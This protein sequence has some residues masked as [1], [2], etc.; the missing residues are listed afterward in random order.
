[1]SDLH[2]AIL[3]W[4]TLLAPGR[5]HSANAQAISSA[6][7][8]ER[9]LFADDDLRTKT[10]ALVVSMA[11]RESSFRND[12]KSKTNDHCLMQVHGRPE[13]ADDAE[14]CVRVAIGMIRESM[15]MCPEAPLAFYASGPGSCSNLRAQRISRDRMSIA[16]KLL[17]VL[18]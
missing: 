3:A 15:R 16:R 4:M 11:F 12:V 8:D 5:D 9:P 1:M 2:S 7:E 17:T 18:P 14:K 10:A 6:V 13:L